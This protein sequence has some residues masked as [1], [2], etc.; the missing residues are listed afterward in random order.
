M[1]SEN[2]LITITLPD[3][4]QR[5][6]PAPTSIADI[7]ASIGPGLAK[8]TIAGW[9][10]EQQVDAHDPINHD[11]HIKIIT[12]NDEAG[13]EIIRHSCAHLIGHAVKQLYPTAKMVIGPVIENGFY[14]DIAYERAF[15]ADDL[16]AIE[17]RMKELIAKNYTVVKK[18][19]PRDEV[20]QCFQ[21]RGEE[22]KLRLI[23]DM[24]DETTMGLY[25]HEEYVD[26]CRGPHVTNTR[27][28]KHFKLTKLSGAYWR[29]DAKNEQLQRIY[30]TAWATKKDLQAYIK[31]IEEAE[32]RDHRRLGKELDLFHF[33]ED[34]PGSVFWHPRGWKVFQELIA[35]MRRRQ[36]A[37]DYVEVNTPDLMDRNLWEISGHWQNYRENMFTT[38]TEDER[39]LALKP[40]NCPGGVLMY[41]HGL[42][43]YRDLPI[44]I[45]EFGKVHRYEPSGSLHGLM[46][47]RHFTQDDAHIFCTTGQM[48][49]ECRR[50]IELVLDIYEQFGFDDVRIKLSTRPE[51]RMGSDEVWDLLEGALTESLQSLSLEYG[52]NPGEGAFYGPKLEFV[53]RDSIGRDWQCGTLQVDMNL[54]ERFGLEYVDEQGQRQRPVMLH[55][56]LFGSLE[57]FTG[58]LIEHHAGKLPPWLSPTQAIVLPISEPFNDYATEVKALLEGEGLRVNTDLSNEKIGYKIRQQ[59]LNR[60]PF[61]LIAG[62]KEAESGQVTIRSLSGEDLGCMSVFNAISLLKEKAQAPDRA[63]RYIRT[64]QL[65]KRFQEKLEPANPQDASSMVEN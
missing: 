26:M 50:V 28:L 49:E 65:R 57:R 55:R 46:R 64:E 52:V 19:T 61:M 38:T 18:M 4:S 30:G 15:T 51:N 47:V 21:E 54:P 34:A 56:A 22:Y 12:P 23:D 44:R 63:M 7:A 16:K 31:R 40:M 8:N 42:K 17:G 9:V 43:S 14:Y 37:A 13:V 33:H 3:G 2:S 32:K 62:G 5:E 58:I 6:Y 20:I 36:Q 39:T 35:Y 41:R 29:G 24:P 27:F 25:H 59:T 45:A 53:L 60:V 1:N 48:Q 10:D 11:A